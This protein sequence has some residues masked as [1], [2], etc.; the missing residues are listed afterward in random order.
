MELLQEAAGPDCGP[1]RLA[2]IHVDLNRAVVLERE[3]DSSP[4]EDPGLRPSTVLNALF[5][6]TVENDR[7]ALPGLFPVFAL[8]CGDREDGQLVADIDWSEALD[9][10]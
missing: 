7:A 2:D 10:R 6:S 8:L 9:P 1:Q 4:N 5:A 3:A